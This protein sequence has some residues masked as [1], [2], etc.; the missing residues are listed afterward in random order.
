[1]KSAGGITRVGENSDFLKS[2]FSVIFWAGKRSIT[3][4]WMNTSGHTHCDGDKDKKLV[5]C[6]TVDH[7]VHEYQGGSITELS[8][9]F[10]SLN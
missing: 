10:S 1:M 4:R 2:L 6:V 3:S 9:D 8:T 7:A 5:Y